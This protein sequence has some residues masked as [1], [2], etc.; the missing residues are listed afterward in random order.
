M[1]GQR[2]FRGIKGTKDLI[3]PSGTFPKGEGWFTAQPLNSLA[4][5][6]GEG[7]L[8]QARRMRSFAPK[9]SLMLRKRFMLILSK[10]RMQKQQPCQTECGGIANREGV[11]YDDS[12]R[13]FPA[14]ATEEGDKILC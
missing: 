12:N 1:R 8:P 2:C 10:L 13:S 9:I 6:Y 14:R 4:F 11:C 3:R 7:G 5:P